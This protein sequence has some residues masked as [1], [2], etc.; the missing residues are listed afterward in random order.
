MEKKVKKDEKEKKVK[1][2]NKDK[3]EK[4][5]RGEDK[6][7]KDKKEKKVKNAKETKQD[8]NNDTSVCTADSIGHSASS[9]QNKE[10]G[11]NGDQDDKVNDIFAM[12]DEDAQGS[13]TVAYDVGNTEVGTAE[14]D[15]A[16][17]VSTPQF[18][19][20]ATP[21]ALTQVDSPAL[22]EPP[23]QVPMEEQ[24]V[25]MPM[26]EQTVQDQPVALPMEEE[27]VQD[28]PV[29]VPPPVGLLKRRQAAR[30]MMHEGG[31]EEND[32]FTEPPTSAVATGPPTDAVAAITPTSAVATGHGDRPEGCLKKRKRWK[33]ETLAAEAL[34]LN[35]ERCLDDMISGDAIQDDDE[36][37]PAVPEPEAVEDRPEAVTEPAEGGY[38]Q[39]YI[40]SLCHMHY[41]M[42][43]YFSE[44]NWQQ[45]P[46][47]LEQLHTVQKWAGEVSPIVAEQLNARIKDYMTRS[48][49]SKTEPCSG[50]DLHGLAAGITCDEDVAVLCM[51]NL[52]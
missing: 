10:A 45:D 35:L 34:E 33:A 20:Q 23:G 6:N 14:V 12:F 48:S 41:A 43:G 24:T 32:L 29:A 49:P 2:A 7:K 42:E 18:F 36:V 30:Q 22:E 38:M 25:R 40:D 3:K 47:R 26:E 15:I 17:G 21:L 51:E 44:Q 13:E 4:G 5:E 52:I 9:G 39:N 11:S 16:H 50:L 19:S 28:Q 46:R 1:K 31:V 8:G 27:T 37:V